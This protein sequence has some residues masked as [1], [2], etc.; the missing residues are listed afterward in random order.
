MPNSFSTYRVSQIH[1][2]LMLE[3]NQSS[4]YQTV[5]FMMVD[6]ADLKLMALALSQLLLLNMPTNLWMPDNKAL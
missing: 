6:G 3:L 4:T 2:A 5:T 1:T